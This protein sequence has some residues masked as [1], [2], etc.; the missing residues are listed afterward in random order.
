[1][2][3]HIEDRYARKVAKKKKQEELDLEI[4]RK[5]IKRGW[6]CIDGVYTFSPRKTLGKIEVKKQCRSIRNYEYNKYE[7]DEDDLGNENWN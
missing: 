4:S 1:M 3:K 2:A 6:K 5:G 7:E